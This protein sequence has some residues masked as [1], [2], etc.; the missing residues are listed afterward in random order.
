MKTFIA[1]SL[2][3]S[4]SSFASFESIKIK[5]YEPAQQNRESRLAFSF[6]ETNSNQ[7]ELRFPENF[8]GTLLETHLTGCLGESAPGEEVIFQGCLG[9]GQEINGLVP[10]EVEGAEIEERTVYCDKRILNWVE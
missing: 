4:I 1:T 6:K 10:L 7:L 8:R 3:F 9:D 5:C 2:L